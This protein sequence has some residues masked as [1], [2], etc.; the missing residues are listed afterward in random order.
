MVGDDIGHFIEVALYDKV[1]KALNIEQEH[2]P[3]TIGFIKI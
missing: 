3:P 1:C 2:I